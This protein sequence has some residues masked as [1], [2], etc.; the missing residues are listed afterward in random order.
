MTVGWAKIWFV[1]STF[2]MQLRISEGSLNS[3]N[4]C[5]R[6]QSMALVTSARKLDLDWHPTIAPYTLVIIGLAVRSFI[7]SCFVFAYLLSPLSLFV[8]FV[9]FVSFCLFLSLFVSFCLFLSLFVSFCLPLPLP[10]EFPSCWL[11]GP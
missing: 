2:C 7:V 3:T 11:F 9:S 6:R 8:S 10:S 5:P 4:K 1:K